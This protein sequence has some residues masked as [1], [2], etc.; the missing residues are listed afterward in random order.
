[1]LAVLVACGG[2]GGGAGADSGSG[3][4]GSAG[5]SGASPSVAPAVAED[6]PVAA[7]ALAA[8]DE[9]SGH[10][11]EYRDLLGTLQPL[12]GAPANKVAEF[13][14]DAQQRMAD[15]G[16][17]ESMVTVLKAFVAAIPPGSGPTDC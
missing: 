2:G 13:V 6:E 5:T 3:G 7:A 14:V 12:C 16:R 9:R 8:M 1:L 15:R 4:A 10:V 11:G 17:V